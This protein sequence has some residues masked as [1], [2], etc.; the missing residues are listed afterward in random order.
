MDTAIHLPDVRA[1]SNISPLTALLCWFGVF[2]LPFRG[3]S[4]LSHCFG[5]FSAVVEVLSG[6]GAATV[7]PAVWDGT[8]RA[9]D[10]TDDDSGLCV[11]PCPHRIH[12]SARHLPTSEAILVEPCG[13]L[14]SSSP[15]APCE[16]AIRCSP[17]GSL[18]Y[19]WAALGSDNGAVVV[20]SWPTLRLYMRVSGQAETE[21]ASQ[22]SCPVTYCGQEDR[23]F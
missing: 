17:F 9:C 22:K 18:V 7:L 13:L 3:S 1:C 6:C 4:L 19:T 11:H 12:V 16:E 10:G 2:Y 14:M 8:R 15:E 20:W 5:V 21:S 23:L